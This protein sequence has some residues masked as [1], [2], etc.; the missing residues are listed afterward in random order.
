MRFFIDKRKFKMDESTRKKA[1]AFEELTTYTNPEN[2]PLARSMFEA[3]F[4]G[5]WKQYDETKKAKKPTTGFWEGA[6][7]NGSLFQTLGQ[8]KEFFSSVSD[9]DARNLALA[10]F[11]IE[12]THPKVTN[13]TRPPDWNNPYINDPKVIA[14]ADHMHRSLFPTQSSG[15]NNAPRQGDQS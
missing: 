13:P 7:A 6:V 14:E 5:Q 8:L 15:N 4:Y 9:H 3:G 10:K 11:R 12:N 1:K 2:I